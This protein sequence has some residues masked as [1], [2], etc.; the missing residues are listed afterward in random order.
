MSEYYVYSAKDGQVTW[1]GPY[2]DVWAARG[3]RDE[4]RAAGAEALVMHSTRTVRTKVREWLEG[5]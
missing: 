4:L 1:Y 3:M 2:R 5:Q